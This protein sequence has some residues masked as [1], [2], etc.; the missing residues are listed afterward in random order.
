MNRL[1]KIEWYK[2]K[3]HTPFWIFAG[4]HI[5]ILL[6]VF[7]SGKF[8][9]DFLSIKGES[10]DKIVDPSKIPIYEFPDVW[11]NITYVAGFLKIILAI[12]VIISICNEI[13]YGTLR[14]N[15]MNG[16]GRGEFIVSKLFMILILSIMS[17]LFL[18]ITGLTL[19]FIYTPDVDMHA[20]V[21]YSGFLPAY[22]LQL[23][24]YMLLALLLGLLI[25]RTGVTMGLLILYTLI[26]EPIIVFRIKTEW[27]KNLFPLKAI[28]NLVHMPFGKYLL[29]ETQDYVAIQDIGI[30]FMYMAIYI[31][32]IFLVLRKRDL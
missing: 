17:T 9:L 32:L 22:F 10:I 11:H 27:I 14:Q 28:N 13:S 31:Y 5:V 3:Y 1:L 20:V 29:R 6:L 24:C 21:K 25:K 16:L 26:V 30:A 4:L 18:L 12:Y 7:L 23:N 2:L 15:I 19:G 8:F